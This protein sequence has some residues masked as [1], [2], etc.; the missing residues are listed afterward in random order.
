[1]HADILTNSSLS[2][3]CLCGGV[4]GLVCGDREGYEDFERNEGAGSFFRTPFLLTMF[5]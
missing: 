5:L 3:C 4:R 2:V 1:M